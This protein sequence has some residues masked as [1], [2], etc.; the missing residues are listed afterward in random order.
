M[1]YP[2]QAVKGR[3]Y[4]FGFSITSENGIVRPRIESSRL[5]CPNY[6]ASYHRMVQQFAQLVTR[7]D[8]H[9]RDLNAIS[10]ALANRME[11]LRITYHDLLVDERATFHTIAKDLLP[12]MKHVT[13]EELERNLEN[14]P[15]KCAVCHLPFSTQVQEPATPAVGTYAEAQDREQQVHTPVRYQECASVAHQHAFCLREW[16]RHLMK[17]NG[18]YQ[19][20]SGIKKKQH[21]R[22]NTCFV[23]PWRAG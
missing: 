11:D 21:W 13:T 7:N 17:K 10:V 2:Q 1:L 23:D 9:K 3:K 22:C 4:R 15:A 18:P 12:V 14:P 19:R 6:W 5:T 20:I 8:E 16:A